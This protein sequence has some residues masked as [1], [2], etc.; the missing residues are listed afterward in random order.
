MEIKNF[1]DASTATEQMFADDQ[2]SLMDVP[3]EETPEPSMEPPVEP[4]PPAALAEPV[5]ETPAEPAPADPTATA[6]QVAETAAQTAADLSAELEAAHARIAELE[7]Q[8]A[9]LSKQNAETV[10]E[11]V[12]TPPTIDFESLAFADEATRKAAQEKYI[13]DTAEYNRKMFM[14]D[15][16]DDL[17]YAREG[18]MDRELNE[19]AES[20][21]DHAQF[22]GIVEMLPQIKTIIA[23]NPLLSAENVSSEEKL[24]MA[25]LM[26]KG[27]SGV[28]NPPTPPKEPTTEELMAMYNG[29]SAFQEMVEKQR[30][31]QIKN[32]QQVPPLSASSGA[33]NAALNIQEKPKTFEEASRRTR[34][35]FG[36]M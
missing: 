22:A 13:A 35:M 18:R 27:A 34:E 19:L 16:A 17:A 14:R 32:S 30:L 15:H 10:V 4:E 7:G 36:D 9:E 6:A 11:E 1:E 2:L 20:L 5:T 25:Y 28:N 33:A 21:N 23:Q 12:L 31:E 26:A 8:N 3:V 24:A 29:N